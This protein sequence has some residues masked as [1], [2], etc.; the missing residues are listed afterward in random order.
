MTGED[1]TQSDLDELMGELAVRL[2]GQ[3]PQQD[4]SGC[5]DGRDQGQGNQQG[6]PEEDPETGGQAGKAQLMV[7][8]IGSLVLHSTHGARSSRAGTSLRVHP[9]RRNTCGNDVVTRR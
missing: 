2:L 5:H 6:A 1:M 7:G 4:D 8:P 3:V 9:R